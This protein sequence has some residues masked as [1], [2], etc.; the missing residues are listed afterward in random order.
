[1]PFC[2][3]PILVRWMRHCVRWRSLTP[4]ERRNL[5][6]QTHGQNMIEPPVLCCHLANTNEQFRLL[7][8]NFGPRYYKTTAQWQQQQQQKVVRCVD[9]NISAV[10]NSHPVGPDL[11]GGAMWQVVEVGVNAASAVHIGQ[12]L[13]RASEAAV[14]THLV[15]CVAISARV[16]SVVNQVTLTQAAS[17][18]PI[19]T[20][21]TY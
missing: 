15:Q 9:L 16:V 2:C 18:K 12:L 4:E 20:Y 1:M 21:Y 7:S 11:G 5:G 13:G 6:V 17:L 8:N 14:T 3:R 19:T 10:D